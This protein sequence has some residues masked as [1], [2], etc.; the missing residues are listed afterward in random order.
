[1]KR[2]YDK[3]GEYSLK[4]GVPKG[5]DKFAGYVNQGR[6]FK[7]FEDFFGNANPYIEQP[8]P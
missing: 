3:Y 4:N 8:S 7:V 1:M 2:I 6:H 5:V